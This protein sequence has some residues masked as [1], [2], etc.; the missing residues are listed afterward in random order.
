MQ[1]IISRSQELIFT[2][3]LSVG[4]SVARMKRDVSGALW[5]THPVRFAWWSTHIFGAFGYI[6]KSGI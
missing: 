3:Y 5:L 1:S 2:D 4:P 6:P